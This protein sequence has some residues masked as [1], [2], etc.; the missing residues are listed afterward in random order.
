MSEGRDT[1][2]V[3]TKKGKTN[4]NQ[5]NKARE[6]RKPLLVLR[7]PCRLFGNN[8]NCWQQVSLPPMRKINV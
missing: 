6:P 4:E 8:E 2:E 3:D 1:L 5:T 7:T